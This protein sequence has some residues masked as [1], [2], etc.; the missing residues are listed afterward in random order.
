MPHRRNISETEIVT[1][2]AEKT[3][4]ERDMPTQEIYEI[5]WDTIQPGSGIDRNMGET[6]NSDEASIFTAGG[7]DTDSAQEGRKP[8][9][10]YERG[11]INILHINI[12]LRIERDRAAAEAFSMPH[13][14]HE[15]VSEAAAEWGLDALGSAIGAIAGGLME[16]DNGEIRVLCEDEDSDHQPTPLVPFSTRTHWYCSSVRS[17][18]SYMKKYTVLHPSPNR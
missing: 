1:V 8:R 3:P 14:A 7:R 6:K 4:P 15:R 13:D 17:V 11:A 12:P 10:K 2:K 16:A 18:M 9:T 5:D